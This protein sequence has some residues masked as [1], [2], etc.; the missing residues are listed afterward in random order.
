MIIHGLSM[1]IGAAVAVAVMLA[2]FAVFSGVE[3]PLNLVDVP[4]VQITAVSLT[5]NGSPPLGDKDAP[6]TI[7]EFGDYQCFFCNK[8]YHDTEKRLIADF[9]DTGKVSWIFKDFTIIGP[10]SVGAAIGARCATDQGMFWEYHDVLYENW[11]GENN[12]WASAKHLEEFAAQIGLNQKEWRE[13][14]QSEKHIRA[15]QASNE[16]AKALGISGTPAF[17]IIGPDG[18]TALSGAQPYEVFANALNE[19]M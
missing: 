10:D 5:E 16:N 4:P 14:I 8:F 19:Q 6:I 18:I 12:G 7:V 17:F 2:A 15:L 9:I 1:T 13:C 11:D 3:K